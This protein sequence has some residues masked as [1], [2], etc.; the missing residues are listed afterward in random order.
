MTNTIRE[1]DNNRNEIHYR[2]SD[3]YEWW[4]DYDTNGKLIHSR[5]SDGYEWWY[6]YDTNGK[7]IHSRDSDGY[8]VWREYDINGKL[9]N[10]RNTSGAT[11]LALAP[12]PSVP[13]GEAVAWAVRADDG[14]IVHCNRMR[15]GADDFAAWVSVTGSTYEV[16][17]LY[18]APPQERVSE[19]MCMAA[20]RED[21]AQR[22]ESF[23][24]LWS[25]LSDADRAESIEDMRHILTAAL[26]AGR[27]DD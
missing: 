22:G 3:G 16:I 15:G 11:D 4:Y 21:H 5:D 12:Q 20:M 2:T 14:A 18:A 24:A 23:D 26:S 13:S 17:P 25:E 19:A 9:I 1:Y 27:A 6:D 8:E 7:L 10:T